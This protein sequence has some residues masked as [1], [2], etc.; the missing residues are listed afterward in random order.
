LESDD[1]DGARQLPQSFETRDDG[2][3]G[4]D[5]MG[6]SSDDFERGALSHRKTP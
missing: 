2:L 6:A 1:A 4:R 5:S 3:L